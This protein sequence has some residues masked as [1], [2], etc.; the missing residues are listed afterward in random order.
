MAKERPILF[1]GE[2]VKGILQGHKTMTRRVIFKD[3]PAD[4][5]PWK[6]PDGWQDG[7]LALRCPYVIGNHLWVKERCAIG[8]NDDGDLV[9]DYLADGKRRWFEL[10]PENEKYVMR[11]IN[12][13]KR[14]SI[15]MPKWASR[16]SLRITDVQAEQLWSITEDDAIAE[17]ITGPH[18][19][20]YPAFRVPGDS[21]PRCSSAK[22][23]FADLWDAINVERGYSWSSNPW[24]WVIKFSISS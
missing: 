6:S 8:F 23:A 18:D 19:V 15:F 1:S 14:P 12:D 5:N 13:D 16:I 22:A 11:Y 3:D 7:D 10:T 4:H 17:G 9:C 24:V 21:K 2:M 20:G